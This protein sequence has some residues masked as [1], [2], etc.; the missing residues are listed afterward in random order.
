MAHT[1]P[2]VSIIVV[3]YNTRDMTLACLR[4]VVAQTTLPY[5]LL[6]MD[7]ASSDGSAEAIADEFPDARFFAEVENH[8]FAKANNMLAELATGDLVLLLNPDTVILDGAI[9]KLVAFS[10]VQPQA[11][12]WGGRTVFGDGQL[13]PY[14]V[15]RKM[16]LWSVFCRTTGLTGLF[17]NSALFNSE[18][19][20]GWD[21]ADAREVDVVVGCFFLMKREFWAELGGFDLTF[22]MYG[23]EAD[24]CLRASAK[25][26]RPMMSPE[27]TIVHYGAASETVQADKMVRILKAKIT[28]INRHFP[29]WQRPIAK[30]LFALW[31][32][33][34]SVATGLR[35]LIK[36][37]DKTK[38][39]TW[40]QVWQRRSEW[41]YG[42]QTQ[43]AAK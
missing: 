43:I 11:R 40:A 42:Y 27:A 39:S 4:S 37:N 28:L 38:A 16:D 33:T 22:F 2:R 15:W 8:G 34:R 36:T 26:A 32:L 24:L 21:R 13:N 5:E 20:G 6:I 31:P 10:E 30:G 23:E 17:P 1:P 14:S 7:N 19:Y 18:A 25:G 35:G 9:D 3:S 29:A 12:I 41:F